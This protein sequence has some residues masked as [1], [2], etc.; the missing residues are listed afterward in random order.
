[1]ISKEF[2]KQIEVIA[3]EKGITVEQAL[4]AT[5]KGL[6]KAYQKGHGGASARVEFKP[7]KNEVL[8]YSQQLVVT[9][10][11]TTGATEMTQ[12]LLEDAKKIS[13]RYKVGDIVEQVVKTTDFGRTATSTGKQVFN[14]TLKTAEKEN[15]LEYFKSYENEMVT[16]EVTGIN[17]KGITLALGMG[18]TT[19]LPTRE[20]LSNDNFRMGDRVKVYLVSVETGTKGPKIYVSRSDKNLV[21]RLMENIIPEIKEGIIE[22]R[23]IARD[24]GDRSKVAI[25]SNDERVDPIGSCVGEG[26]AR[27][28]EVVNALN[29]EKIDLYRYSTVPE[30]LIANSLQ[31]ADVVAV[32]DVEP[33]GKT[34]LAIVP[35]DQ[36]SLAI[37]RA[38]QN[39]RL[40]VQ[41]CGWK[42]DIKSV[43]D[44]K[45]EGISF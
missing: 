36:L 3:E 43:S 6:V 9:E 23:G 20:I 27:I 17:D 30:E 42:I 31:P 45:A 11:D 40:A 19:L 26:G 34:S 28:R 25:Y 8:L 33:K 16:A 12:I 37:G 24:A 39:V 15:V 2:F 14:Q 41:S 7:E 18:T 29:G 38:G 44:A 4:D 21:T 5:A 35:D 1:M 13:N 32:I 10:I 22:I